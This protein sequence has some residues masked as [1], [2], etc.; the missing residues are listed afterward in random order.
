MAILVLSALLLTGSLVVTVLQMR[1]NGV[2]ETSRLNQAIEVS[3]S[4]QFTFQIY[5]P[6]NSIQGAN[7]VLPKGEEYFA[8]VLNEARQLSA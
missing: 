1:G 5:C 3:A 4:E 2:I 7:I 8:K 6:V